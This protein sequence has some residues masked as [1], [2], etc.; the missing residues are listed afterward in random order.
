MK[1]ALYLSIVFILLSGCNI[2]KK[3]FTKLSSSKTN[4]DFNNKLF[5][6]NTRNYLTYPYMYLGAG[7]AAGDFNNDGLEDLFFTGN[8]VSNKLFLNQGNLEF[9]DISEFAGIKVVFWCYFN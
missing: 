9:K 2:E 1:I 8:M 6:T 7:V 5:E 4:I 3:Q